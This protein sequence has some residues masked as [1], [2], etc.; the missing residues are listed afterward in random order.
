MDTLAFDV[1]DDIVG[2]LDMNTGQYEPYRGK[3]KTVAAERLINCVGVLVSFNG[4]R[5]DLLRLAWLL[6]KTSVDE[7][8]IQ[9]EHFDMREIAS[10]HRWPPDPGTTPIR[11]ESLLDTYAHYYPDEPVIGPPISFSDDYDISNCQDCWMAGQL[12]RKLVSPEDPTA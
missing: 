10:I 8:G 6:G 11:G 12:W 7:L 2:V 3:R 1:G 5:Y 4:N 9:A